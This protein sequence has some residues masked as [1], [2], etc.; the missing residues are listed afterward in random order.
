MTT[1]TRRTPSKLAIFSLVTGACLQFGCALMSKG[2]VVS[3]RYFSPDVQATADAAPEPAPKLREL[4][5]GQVDAASHLEERM[6]YRVTPTE[7]GYYEDRRWTEDPQEYLRRALERELFER[8]QVRRVVTGAADTLDVELT[9]FEELRE[10]SP[11]VRLAL[12]YVLHDDRESLLER[13]VV[14]ERPLAAG[15]DADRPERVATALGAALAEAVAK[16]SDAVTAA[17]PAREPAPCA[18][19]VADER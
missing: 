12:T 8:K 5:L 17:V 18:T 9:A 11:H 10:P 3:P 1:P 16:V 19:S 14:V 13:S 15:N 4:R 7:L 6:A 2:S